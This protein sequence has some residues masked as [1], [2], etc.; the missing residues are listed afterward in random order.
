MQ[1]SNPGAL[2]GAQGAPRSIAAS[3]SSPVRVE[4]ELD[5]GLS[6]WMWLIKW[7]L[8]IPHFFVLAFLWVAF[9]VLTVIALFA[10]LF[11]GATRGESS[12][13]TSA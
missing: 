8:L 9:V 11:T 13:S 5:G 3:G 12:T 10:I 6:R 2:A 1:D 4:G 7:V